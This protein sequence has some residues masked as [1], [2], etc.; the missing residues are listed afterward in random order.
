MFAVFAILIYIAALAI[1]VVLLYELRSRAWYWH[2]LAIAGALALGFVPTPA[3]M[4]TPGFDLIFG[5][6]FIVL[7]VWGVGGLVAFHGPREKHA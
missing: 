3:G 7:M 1:P 6:I 5:C 4:H 2:G